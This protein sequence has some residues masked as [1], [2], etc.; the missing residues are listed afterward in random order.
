MRKLYFY[1]ILFILAFGLSCGESKNKDIPSPK[2]KVLIIDGQNNHYIWPKTSMI[3][4]SYLEQ[5]G[6][7]DVKTTHMDTI[8]L[9][10]KYNP[11]RSGT[12]TKYIHEF[13]LDSS[14]HVISAQPTKNSNFNIDF[15]NYDLI[16][17]NLGLMVADWPDRT[18]R[19]FEKYINEGGGLVVVHAANNSWG[20]WEEYNKMIGLGAWD[21][22]D[23]ISGP[24]VFYNSDREIEKD[25]SK[26]VAGSHGLEHEYT[27]TSRAPEHP[28]MKGLPL[29][30]IHA[31]DEL[32]D[33]MRGPFENATILATAYSDSE[34]NQQPW[35]PAMKGTGWNVPTLM[36]INYGKGRIFHTTLGHFDYSM[37]CVG[38]MTTFQR[39]SE[40]AATGKV[41]QDIPDDFPSKDKSTSRIWTKKVGDK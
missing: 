27:I 21:G 17:S 25:H 38:F 13:P 31:K 11:N 12:L 35:E 6:L 36:A 15:S 2:L 4:G 10:I 32:Y 5:T 16:V 41:N 8:W 1:G 28:I 34:K 26:G 29:T 14:K 9:G 18:K 3:M 19:N 22:R 37:E 24:Y 20:N 40:W 30:W 23:S 33:R 39:G 7:F